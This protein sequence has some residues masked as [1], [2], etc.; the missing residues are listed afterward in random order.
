MRRREF[1][2]LLV[3]AA[4]WPLAARARS[5]GNPVVGI[6]GAGS[7]RRISRIFWPRCVE[8]LK[9]IGY[10][11]G[12]NVAIKYRFAA[13]RFD[14][15][16]WLADD[17]FGRGSPSWS[18][19]ASARRSRPRVQAHDSACVSQP[20]RSVKLGFVASLNRPG[21]NATGV[22]LLTAE[23]EASAIEVARQLMPAGAPR[24]LSH[25]SG[26]FRSRAIPGEIETV[27][28]ASTKNRRS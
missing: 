23:L 3:G 20:G 8:G 19:P 14:Q 27:A 1:N 28:R 15:L 6:L 10:A 21:G 22:S 13:G 12:Q 24:R 17:W 26:G 2:G 4:T 9:D 16:P 7:Q 18:R 11:E 5:T 25:E